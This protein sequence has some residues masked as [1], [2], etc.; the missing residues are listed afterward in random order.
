MHALLSHV[1]AD[2]G[3]RSLPFGFV[4]ATLSPWVCPLLLICLDFL[5]L[6]RQSTAVQVGVM[7][8]EHREE[9]G[10]LHEYIQGS[11]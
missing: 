9:V 7:V 1:Q 3:L 8:D 11:Y 10:R 6:T 2:A 4:M 5:F